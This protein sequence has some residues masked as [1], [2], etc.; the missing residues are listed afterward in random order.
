MVQ[1]A[2]KYQEQIRDCL[3]RLADEVARN[4]IPEEAASAVLRS[5][6]AVLLRNDS[7]HRWKIQTVL[8][9]F[10]AVCRARGLSLEEHDSRESHVSDASSTEEAE[11]GSGEVLERVLGV[12]EEVLSELGERLYRERA[13]AP[14]L[15]EEIRRQPRGR[16]RWLVR[17]VLRFHTLGLAEHLLDLVR[18]LWH[19]DHVEAEQLCAV[20]LEICE[21]L[22]DATYGNELIHDLRAQTLAFLANSNRTLRHLRNV[23]ET[24]Q[25]A[26][27]HL[28]KGTGDPSLRALHHYLKALF[29]AQQ[30]RFEEAA[31]LL[32]QAA[33]I[34]KTIGNLADWARVMIQKALVMQES[35][36]E[37]AAL[38][39]L[40]HVAEI[41]RGREPRVYFYAYHN[42]T[43]LL[44][45]MGRTEEALRRI[46][47]GR[48]LAEEAGG[49]I[50]R[51]KVTWLEGRI[52]SSAGSFREAEEPLAEAMRQLLDL[53]RDLEGISA[54]LDLMA[55]YLESSR[56][57]EALGLLPPLFAQARG[58]SQNILAALVTLH[59]A[60]REGR[61]TPSL[62][63][64]VE[65]FL[66]R[67]V[68]NPSLRF[69]LQGGHAATR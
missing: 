27:F 22:S 44:W 39:I 35:E 58:V 43:D 50:D 6:A 14:A 51:L 69:E 56:E 36:Q 30:R 64:E 3:P 57:E 11:A 63:R 32:D 61:A 12:L 15:A 31:D 48:Q 62:V 5:T 8:E 59:Q 46:E 38:E 23:E 28:E 37:D 68:S 1:T 40:N 24:F 17:N 42:V 55:L 41:T 47:T 18:E 53:H 60:L 4:R 25:A 52:L 45:A 21:Q 13:N 29:R 67:A 26:S 2:G 54:A 33:S 20:A 19:S 34:Y 16:R 66:D 49:L 65:H 9:T 7:G 10:R